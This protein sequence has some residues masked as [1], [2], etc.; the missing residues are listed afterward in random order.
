MKKIFT[1]CIILLTLIAFAG[2]TLAEDL[3][4]TFKVE[5]AIAKKDKNGSPYVR[6]LVQDNREL[7]GV[8]YEKTSNVLAFNDQ[9]GPASKL[10]KG[11]TINVIVAKSDFRGGVSYQLLKILP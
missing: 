9:V 4:T 10:K 3:Q 8:V 11:D 6:I 5:R 1:L 2:I 7:N